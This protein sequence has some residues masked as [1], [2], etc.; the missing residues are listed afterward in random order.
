[1]RAFFRG[2]TTDLPDLPAEATAELERSS[3]LARFLARY[4]GRPP[5]LVLAEMAQ[6]ACTQRLPGCGEILKIWQR[7]APDSERLRQARANAKRL[8]AER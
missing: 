4:T 8:R 2:Q 6:E 7:I 3:L 5:E 1:V